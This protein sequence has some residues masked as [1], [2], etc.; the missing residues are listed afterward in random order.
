MHMS[1][2]TVA[3]EPQTCHSTTRLWKAWRLVTACSTWFL[4]ALRYFNHWIQLLWTSQKRFN[5][6]SNLSFAEPGNLRQDP[7]A[8]LLFACSSNHRIK[9]QASASLL[10][11][12]IVLLFA[13]KLSAQPISHPSARPLLPSPLECQGR[14]L[15]AL[16]PAWKRCSERWIEWSGCVPAAVEVVTDRRFIVKPTLDLWN[17][18]VQAGQWLCL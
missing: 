8:L 14:R 17:P 3:S 10:L 4:S 16:W 7:V 1:T 15:H 12:S 11:L 5:Q 2:H 9:Y 18:L 13:N 6:I